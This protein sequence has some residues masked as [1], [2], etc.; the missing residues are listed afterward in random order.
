MDC[1]QVQIKF[2]FHRRV[3]DFVEYYLREALSASEEEKERYILRSKELNEEVNPTTCEI[4]DFLSFNNYDD[5]SQQLR[6]ISL[7]SMLFDVPVRNIALTHNNDK[8]EVYLSFI[9]ESS[10]FKTEKDI[11]Y[12]INTYP[13]EDTYWEGTIGNELR[14]PSSKD[15]TDLLGELSF[16]CSAKKIVEK[17]RFPY[18]NRFNRLLF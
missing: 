7:A 5:Q 12:Y 1:F 2:I 17:Q 9:I 8:D 15:S 10:D 3:D 6:Y 11:E 16:N 4:W 18:W 14:I 13:L